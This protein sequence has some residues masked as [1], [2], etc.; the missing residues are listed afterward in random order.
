[1]VQVLNLAP[2]RVHIIDC[3][4]E[5]IEPNIRSAFLAQIKSHPAHNILQNRSISLFLVKYYHSPH[6]FAD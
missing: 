5:V 2:H 1:M 4:P 6:V 3:L